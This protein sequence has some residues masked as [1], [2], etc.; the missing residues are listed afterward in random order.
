TPGEYVALGAARQAA[1]A[2]SGTD[3]PPAWEV[4]GETFEPGGEHTSASSAAREAYR[5]VLGAARP[6]LTRG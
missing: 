3:S 2:L 4:S 1:W 5:A 6:L